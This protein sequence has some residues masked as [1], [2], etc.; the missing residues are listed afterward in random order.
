MKVAADLLGTGLRLEAGEIVKLTPATNIP[1]GKT[2]WF[3]RS[4]HWK[5]DGSIL[6]EASEVTLRGWIPGRSK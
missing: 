6:I 3:A 1:N 4:I 5:H 2:K